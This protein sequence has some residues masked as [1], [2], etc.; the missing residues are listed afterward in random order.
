[1]EQGK[2]DEVEE[3]LIKAERVIDTLP[4]PLDVQLPILM[5]RATA[6]FYQGD[7]RGA[8]HT[9]RNSL[10]LAQTAQTHEFLP[11]IHAWRALVAIQ[12]GELGLAE[13]CWADVCDIDTAEQ[14]GAQELYHLEWLKAFMETDR[15]QARRQLLEAADCVRDLDRSSYLKLRWLAEGNSPSSDTEFEQLRAS[16]TETHLGWFMYFSRRWF[17]A[18]SGVRFS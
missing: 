15:T 13:K 3:S 17:R 7:L 5:N 14:K 8:E 16:L 4:D 1:M 2:W 9:F 10:G 12:K 6:K 11:Q 18:A